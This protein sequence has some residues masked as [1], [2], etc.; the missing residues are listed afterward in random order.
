MQ[1]TTV[2]VEMM[3]RN[4][5]T[6]TMHYGTPAQCNLNACAI[7]CDSPESFA[8]PEGI[9]YEVIGGQW[10]TDFGGQRHYSHTKAA[11][12]ALLPSR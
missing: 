10:C 4:P 11:A 9:V 3:H 12:V 5:V 2:D 8:Y 7:D 6:G 1:T